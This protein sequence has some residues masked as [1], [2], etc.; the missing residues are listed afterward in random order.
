VDVQ[1]STATEYE[2][3][4]IHLVLPFETSSTHAIDGDFL[5]G[6]NQVQPIP[7][8]RYLGVY[9]DSEMSLRSHISHVWL[10]H[11]SVRCIKF[12]PYGDRCHLSR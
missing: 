11:V 3:Y 6:A 4:G 1:P 7:S 12:V 9:V 10:P 8:A 5:V 2:Q